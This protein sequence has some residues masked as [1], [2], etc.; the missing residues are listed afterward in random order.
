MTVFERIT[1][2]R[3]D[4]GLSKIAFAKELNISD[5]LV[6][7]LETGKRNLTPRTA[8]DICDRFNV[9]P[10]WLKDGEGEPYND[11]VPVALKL[12]RAEY[13]LDDLDLRIIQMY[14][15]MSS[16]ERQAFK[17]YI[18]KIGSAD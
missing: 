12:L 2:V 9:N 10:E 6:N 13:N 3:T 5:S 17:N 4:A 1:K 8:S 14:M 7:L 18:K 15:S 11:V 16:E